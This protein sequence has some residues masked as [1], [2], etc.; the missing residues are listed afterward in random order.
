ME[1]P[2]QCGLRFAVK[3]MCDFISCYIGTA[4]TGGNNNFK[5]MDGSYW[6]GLTNDIPRL[7]NHAYSIHEYSRLRWD[8]HGLDALGLPQLQALSTYTTNSGQI[9]NKYVLPSEW[10]N[11]VWCEKR[12]GML[13]SLCSS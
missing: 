2:K 3:I 6:A 8:S 13:L 12:P 4:D 9:I 5:A 11:L 10:G 1:N 7:N